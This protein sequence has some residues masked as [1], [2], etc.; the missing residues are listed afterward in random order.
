MK[1]MRLLTGAVFLILLNSLM[2]SRLIPWIQSIG[3][4]VSV[5]KILMTH[6]VMEFIV[7]V[8]F[9]KIRTNTKYVWK[10]VGAY[11]MCAYLCYAYALVITAFV[12]V[13]VSMKG[14]I[15]ILAGVLFLVYGI[16]S[17][18]VLKVKTYQIPLLERDMNLVLLS[19]LHIGAVGSESRISKIVDQIN[20]LEPDIVCISGDVFD[21]FFGSI[22][23]PE[24]VKMKLRTIQATYGVYACLGNHDA[25]NGIKEM[26][27]FLEESN[28]ILLNDSYVMIADKLIL[29]GRLDQMPHGGY[30]GMKRCDT[31]DFLGRIKEAD[32]PVIVMEHNPGHLREYDKRVDLILSGHTHNGQQ[33]P[34]NLV[35]KKVFECAYGH[36]RKDEKSPHIIVTSGA[37]TWGMPLRIG[38]SNEIVG[39]TL[40]TAN[41]VG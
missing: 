40:G 5:G 2:I 31:E 19:D 7:L 14:W 15:A 34:A 9:K 41:S 22:R 24:K 3:V 37:G 17:A 10:C 6:I 30:G 38:T 18:R 27:A 29:G 13:S 36:Y 25:G 28:I 1:K 26:L 16:Y 23:N 33:F 8:C 21:N 39:I 4:D 32:L 11:G 12:P 20:L 35:L